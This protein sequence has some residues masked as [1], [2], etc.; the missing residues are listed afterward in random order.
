VRLV[1]FLAGLL[2]AIGLGISGMTQPA[3]VAGFLDFFG[4]WDPSLMFVMAG[5]IG[6]H[7]VFARRALSS[8][9]P[10]F[11][12]RFELPELRA[13]DARLVAGAAIFGVGWGMAGLCPGPA[14]V[15][16]VSGRATT[17]AFVLAMV[18]TILVYRRVLGDPAITR[19]GERARGTRG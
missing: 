4:R 19:S 18:A 14:L 17:I 13:I 8:G 12:A 10:R 2:F 5:A 3:K 11:A 9:R 16:L 6:A 1:G 7:F 15:A